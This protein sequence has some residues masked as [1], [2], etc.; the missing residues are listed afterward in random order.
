MRETTGNRP[1][2]GLPPL[3]RALALAMRHIEASLDLRLQPLGLAAREAWFL[4]LLLEAGSE[5]TTTLARRL[6]MTF[7]T[8]TQLVDRL[9]RAGWVLRQHDPL[10]RRA[11]RLRLSASGRRL[12]LQA[13]RRLAALERKLSRSVRHRHRE[14]FQRVLEAI[15]VAVE[16]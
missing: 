7:S 16:T 3:L 1:K 8:M 4:L 11:I 12:A 5:H 6:G 2:A 15:R 13:S 10:D 9:E 14:S